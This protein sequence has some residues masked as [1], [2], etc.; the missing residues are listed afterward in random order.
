MGN[1]NPINASTWQK[2]A[3]RSRTLY[4][5]VY[6]EDIES[7]NFVAPRGTDKAVVN[8]RVDNQPAMQLALDSA[9]LQDTMHQWPDAAG[10]TNAGVNITFL[11]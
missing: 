9:I 10:K 8:I 1:L 11:Y 3:L 6:F 2:A 5:S 4:A 7:V